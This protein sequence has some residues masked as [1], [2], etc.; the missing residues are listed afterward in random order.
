MKNPFGQIVSFEDYVE[1]TGIPKEQLQS[2]EVKNRINKWL[3]Q[4]TEQ[5]D[6]MI[7]RN[8]QLVRLYH[9]YSA[10]QDNEED[11]YKKY[12]LIKAICS[13]VETFVIK[14]KFWVDGLPVI[15]S[16]VDIQINSSSNNSNVDA[17]NIKIR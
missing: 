12:K 11:N 15:N 5:F 13:W 10:L 6:S 17:D 3:V 9:W 8:G 16:N 1:I 7:T 2:E 14:G 4:A